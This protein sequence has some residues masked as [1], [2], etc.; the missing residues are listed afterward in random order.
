MSSENCDAYVVYECNTGWCYQRVDYDEYSGKWVPRGRQNKPHNTNA[1]TTLGQ[2]MWYIREKRKDR[3]G[4]I[5]KPN[6]P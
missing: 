4:E 3:E 6:T 5:D 1:F 2:L